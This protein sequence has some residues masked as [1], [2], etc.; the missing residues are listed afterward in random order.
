MFGPWLLLP[1]TE[2]FGIYLV[3]PVTVLF[4]TLL[5]GAFPPEKQH[6]PLAVVTVLCVSLLSGF[7]RYY[8]TP[9][10]ETGGNSQIA[11]RTGAIDPKQVAYLGILEETQGAPVRIFAHTWWIEQ[12]LRY[13]AAN[14]T[15]VEVIE[16]REFSNPLHGD[17]VITFA[18]E[19]LDVAVRKDPGAYVKRWV[20]LDHARREVLAVYR[21]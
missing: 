14:E 5:H 9:I 3:F 21:L 8:F 20:V 11:F 17:Y 1:H 2:R 7:D 4:V 10:Q 6:W 12:P 15:S 18:G 19:P 13:L 16:L